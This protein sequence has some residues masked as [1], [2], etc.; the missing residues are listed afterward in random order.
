MYN[1]VGLETT[2]ASGTN[3]FVQRNRAH[4]QESKNRGAYNAEE[5]I[6]RAELVLNRQPNKVHYLF[7]WINYFI[8]L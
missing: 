6:K 4:I 2:R 5:D 1:G 3:G 8:Y 7:I